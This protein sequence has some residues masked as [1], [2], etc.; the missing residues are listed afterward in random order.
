MATKCCGHWPSVTSA[1]NAGQTAQQQTLESH[2]LVVVKQWTAVGDDDSRETHSTVD[3]QRVK[4]SEGLF[5]V[6][7]YEALFPGDGN[8]P[9]H[10]RISCRCGML[11]DAI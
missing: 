5:N 7:G 10:E 1:L 11:T 4:G 9:G 6:G 3:R 8:L 2:E